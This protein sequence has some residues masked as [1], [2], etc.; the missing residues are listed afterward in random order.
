[1]ESI[2]IMFKQKFDCIDLP[3]MLIKFICLQE[4]R[5]QKGKIFSIRS[6]LFD[7][8]LEAKRTLPFTRKASRL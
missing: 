2:R 8:G 5:V 7:F 1:M 4:K 6:L 3:V